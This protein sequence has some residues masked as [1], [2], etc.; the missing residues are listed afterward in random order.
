MVGYACVFSKFS[1]TF[2]D[3]LNVGCL[4]FNTLTGFDLLTDL[5]V[6]MH[7][8]DWQLVCDSKHIFG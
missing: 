6:V 3:F 4:V 5:D 2:S 8:L 7:V 1:F